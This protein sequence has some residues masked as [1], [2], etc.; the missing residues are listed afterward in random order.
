VNDARKHLLHAGAQ[1]VSR[2]S[3]AFRGL[4]KKNDSSSSNLRRL[5]SK[6]WGIFTLF[7]KTEVYKMTSPLLTLGVPTESPDHRLT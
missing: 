5:R 4:E 7:P 2:I 6:F 1:V 3:R